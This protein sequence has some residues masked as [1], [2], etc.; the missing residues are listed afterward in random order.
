[1]GSLVGPEWYL[2]GDPGGTL[3]NYRT[4]IRQ[5]CVLYLLRGQRRSGELGAFIRVETI[6]ALW[7]PSGQ[8]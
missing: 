3:P 6:Y 2:V 8:P 7:C 5:L 1:M 4:S